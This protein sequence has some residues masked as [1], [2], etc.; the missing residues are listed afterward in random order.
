MRSVL[1]DALLA[2]RR[3]YAKFMIDAPNPFNEALG[4][5]IGSG[6]CIGYHWGQVDADEVLA[7]LG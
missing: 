7:A 6:Y 3:W 1:I 2:R 5:A 4:Y